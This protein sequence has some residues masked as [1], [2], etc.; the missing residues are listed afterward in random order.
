MKYY[1]KNN[2][3]IKED[4]YIKHID[5]YLPEKVY[6]SDSGDLGL[7]A[8]NKNYTFATKQELYPLSE[9]DLNEWEIC[10]F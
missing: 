4:M 8:T 2:K 3:E 9:F 10:T 1:D 5:E 7:N 6:K